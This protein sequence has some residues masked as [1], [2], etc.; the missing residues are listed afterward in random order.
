M[1]MHALQYK[2]CNWHAV[3]MCILHCYNE[4]MFSLSKSMEEYSQVKVLQ[5]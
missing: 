4:W 3:G 1:G 5:I 2:Y